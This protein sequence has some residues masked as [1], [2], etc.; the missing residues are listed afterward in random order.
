VANSS[1]RLPPV[2]RVQRASQEAYE[3]ALDDTALQDALLKRLE[4]DLRAI[5]ILAQQDIAAMAKK[6]AL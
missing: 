3:L 6:T 2:Q 1:R 5:D 4:G